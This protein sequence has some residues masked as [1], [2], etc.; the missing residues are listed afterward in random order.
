MKKLSLVLTAL[1]VM[2]IR[3]SA[4]SYMEARDRALF[5]TDKMA[6][7]LNLT[8]DQYE[9]AYEIN[10]D[11]LMSIDDY[12]NLYG[13][14]WA[15]RNLDLSYILLDW[16]YRT[17]VN[18]TYFYRP[19]YRRGG[20]WYFGIYARYPHRD[21]FYFGRPDFYA[22]Y[23]GGHSWRMNSGRSWYSGRQY[24]MSRERGAAYTGM[25]DGFDRGEF[26][27]GVRMRS[28]DNGY[29]EF[30]NGSRTYNEQNRSSRSFGNGARTDRPQDYR[31]RSFGS[32][33]PR[34]GTRSFGSR[35]SSTRSTAD[36]P[37]PR[38][39]FGNRTE[40]NITP[41]NTFTPNAD[42]ERSFGHSAPTRS[43][44]S[45]APSSRGFG[46]G[47]RSTSP[48]RGFGQGSGNSSGAST[49]GHFGRGR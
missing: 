36:R 33:A 44:N 13:V 12:N 7:E 35:Q 19:L 23:S 37:A 38:R 15:Q 10:L 43:Y 48:S 31:S 20:N 2:T 14:Y 22:S 6:Y 28:S 30:G 9:A 46:G 18:A 41:R 34:S 47:Q 42:R 1:F 25:R 5:L 11:Y 40:G 45:P 29:R 24:G 27:R 4:M 17:Y 26:G 8:P 16:Q 32:D 49:G 3:A 39:S 21:Y